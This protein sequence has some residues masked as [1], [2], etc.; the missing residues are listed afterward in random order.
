VR[1][2]GD[3]HVDAVAGSESVRGG[4]ELESHRG[5]AVGIARRLARGQADER[6][7]DVQRGAVGSMSHTR[8]NT[9]VSS[10]LERNRMSARTGPSASGGAPARSS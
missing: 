6:I 3:L 10:R 7:A 8:T 4:P 2:A 5:H 1:A 9:S